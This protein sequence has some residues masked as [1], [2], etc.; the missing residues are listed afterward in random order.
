MRHSLKWSVRLL[1]CV[2]YSHVNWSSTCICVW[3]L[4]LG[5]VQIRS[6]GFC[7]I[8]STSKWSNQIFGRSHTLIFIQSVHYCLNNRSNNKKRI[9]GMSILRLISNTE[10]SEI[11]I[12]IWVLCKLN[13]RPPAKTKI[14]IDLS[15]LYFSSERNT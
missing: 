11:H 7:L 3:L 12:Y 10:Y 1:F 2:G 6:T 13:Q 4:L 9:S 14:Q 5:P 8:T 15:F